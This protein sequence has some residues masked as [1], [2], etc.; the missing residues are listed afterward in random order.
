[1]LQ[2]DSD[3]DLCT[4]SSYAEATVELTSTQMSRLPKGQQTYT[5]D[6]WVEAQGDGVGD[7]YIGGW[8]AHMTVLLAL[9]HGG[10]KDLIMDEW[11]MKV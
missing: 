3:H 9:T 8:C 6:S 1:M 5:V 7:H 10:S 11:Y 2:G 4:G